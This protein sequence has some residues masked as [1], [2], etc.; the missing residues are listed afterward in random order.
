LEQFEEEPAEDLDEATMQ[1]DSSIKF[2]I[3]NV[4]TFVKSASLVLRCCAVFFVTK[5]VV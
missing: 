3:K 4:F 2:V 1:N 5:I